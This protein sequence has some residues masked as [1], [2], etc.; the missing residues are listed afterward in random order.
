[1]KEPDVFEGLEAKRIAV[2]TD[3]VGNLL[4]GR[5]VAIVLATDDNQL[6]VAFNPGNEMIC[7]RA[8]EAIDWG[9]I[10]PIVEEWAQDELP[11]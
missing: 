3:R 10:R 11:L 4:G 1:M 8:C 9:S 6:S 2:A 5:V 7:W